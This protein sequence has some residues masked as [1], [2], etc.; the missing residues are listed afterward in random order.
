M[1]PGPETPLQARTIRLR[2]LHL[3]GAL[4]ALVLAASPELARAQDSA[5][6][7]AKRMA[8]AADEISHWAEYDY[9]VI[10]DDVQRCLGE[11]RAILIAER[12][13][14]QRQT[15]LLDFVKQLREGR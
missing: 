11:I 7:V 14:R 15:G 8:Q 10:N 5:A 2:P 12:K 6:V 4:I 13:R 3:G 1:P 9:I